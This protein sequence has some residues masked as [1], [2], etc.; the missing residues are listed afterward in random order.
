MAL[1]SLDP[2]FFIMSTIVVDQVG[3]LN[4]DKFQFETLPVG[5]TVESMVGYK[6]ESD[7]QL[8]FKDPTTCTL[9]R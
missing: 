4:I 7:F 3:D 2:G 9:K 5:E 1:V 8:R 6:P